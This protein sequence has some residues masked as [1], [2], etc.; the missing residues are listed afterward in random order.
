MEKTFSTRMNLTAFSEIFSAFLR[1]SGMID[2]NQSVE[3]KEIEQ[4]DTTLYIDGSVKE[5]AIN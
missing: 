1:K 2:R 3:V 4:E 5:E